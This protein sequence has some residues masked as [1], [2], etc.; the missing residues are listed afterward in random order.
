MFK[1][2]Q[3]TKKPPETKMVITRASV[4]IHSPLVVLSRAA[5]VKS[6]ETHPTV[7]GAERAI[8]ALANREKYDNPANP[9]GRRFQEFVEKMNV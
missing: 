5:Q 1:R 7:T 9:V 2:D 4:E 8:V 3:T 6:R